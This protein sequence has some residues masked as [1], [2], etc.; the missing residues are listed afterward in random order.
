MV[1]LDLFLNDDQTSPYNAALFSLTMLMYTET[2]RTYTFRETEQMLK[3]TGF[4]KFKRFKI[5]KGSFLIEAV[6]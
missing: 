2:G 4:K 3:N 5:E 1:V 6:K